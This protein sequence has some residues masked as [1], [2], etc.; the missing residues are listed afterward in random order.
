MQVAHDGS[1]AA[2]GACRRWRT[3]RV[4]ERSGGKRRLRPIRVAA[5]APMRSV[6]MQ[7]YLGLSS[8]F[9]LRH[10]VGTDCLNPCAQMLKQIATFGRNSAIGSEPG[11]SADQPSTWQNG[12]DDSRKVL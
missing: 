12:L 10:N 8:H 5:S 3:N 6:L 7:S 1:K 11:P 4:E 2:R 9:L